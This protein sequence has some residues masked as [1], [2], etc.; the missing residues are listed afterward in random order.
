MVCVKTEAEILEFLLSVAKEHGE[1]SPRAI[2]M[3]RLQNKHSITRT[4][5]FALVVTSNNERLIN[6]LIQASLD[7]SE[8]L[9]FVGSE[10]NLQSDLSIDYLYFEA[11]I[12][13]YIQR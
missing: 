11:N 12:L 13:A 3:T 10:V 9:F 4:V 2:V 5:K 8:D 7:F 6:A 1:V